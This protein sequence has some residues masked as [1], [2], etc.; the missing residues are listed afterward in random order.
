[1]DL[2]RNSIHRQFWLTFLILGNS[3]CFHFQLQIAQAN[4]R[5]ASAEKETAKLTQRFADR[6]LNAT[7]LKAI[8]DKIRP[9]A[10]GLEQGFRQFLQ[11]FRG[12]G[13][14][15]GES[16]GAGLGKPVADA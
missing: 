7:Q 14:E 6:K 4:E 12:A 8:S 11:A 2:I 16:L 3:S 15:I 5:A 9:F 1:M 13:R 10:R